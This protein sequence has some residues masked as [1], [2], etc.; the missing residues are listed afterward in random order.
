MNFGYRSRSA[1]WSARWR[2]GHRVPRSTIR[3]VY[4]IVLISFCVILAGSLLHLDGGT[5]V[6]CLAIAII[7]IFFGE[8]FREYRFR[9]THTPEERPAL[10]AQSRLERDRI[11]LGSQLKRDRFKFAE[12]ATTYKREVLRTGAE[13]RAVITDVAD[14]CDDRTDNT[15]TYLELAVTVG[16]DPPYAVRTGEHPNTGLRVRWDLPVAVGR[17]LPVRVDLTDRQ[18]VAVDWKKVRED[19]KKKE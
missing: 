7:L 16:D 12:S 4:S 5:V 10:A 6:V 8:L 2:V 9:R 17:E 11:K 15:V 3:I 13:A 1:T 18:R 14:L 19:W